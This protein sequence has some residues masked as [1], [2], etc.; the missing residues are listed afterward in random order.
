ML[1][2][3]LVV[4]LVDVVLVVVVAG[5]VVATVVVDE[6]AS[7]AEQALTAK[8][9]VIRRRCERRDR[10][11]FMSGATLGEQEF[12]FDVV[13]FDADDTLWHSEDGFHAAEETFCEL[14]RPFVTEGVDLR[15]VLTATE[16]V[17]LPTYGYGV[18]AFGLSMLEAAIS[19][20][21]GHVSSDVLEKLLS[22][23]RELLLAPVR[24][25]PG[26][27][28]VIVDLAKDHR[29]AIITKGDLVHQTRKV[30]TSGIDHLFDH[31][32]IVLEKDVPTYERV[33]RELDVEP[34]R[35]CMVGNSVKS[36]ALPVLELGGHAVHVPYH[37]LW[38]LERAEH[39][40]NHPRFG[41]VEAI[42][43]VP[44]WVRGR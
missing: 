37:V 12:R 38:E 26:V 39:P 15:A 16:R 22:V 9:I 34:H 6:V 29:V 8:D 21:E 1:V 4:V 19:V 41:Q 40:V 18:K 31:V 13:A 36:D 42:T 23:I 7:T 43:D 3:V 14:L 24:L 10:T 33:L 25:L 27:A 20:S 5:A 2:V 32:E 11:E 28:E 30:S 44:S 17:N 35:F